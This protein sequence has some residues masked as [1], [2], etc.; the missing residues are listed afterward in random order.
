MRYLNC[1]PFYQSLHFLFV[2]LILFAWSKS[3]FL[4]LITVNWK[5]SV[6]KMF[7]IVTLQACE[8]LTLHLGHRSCCWTLCPFG[9]RC[10]A[11]FAKLALLHPLHGTMSLNLS[12]V[13]VNLCLQWLAWCFTIHSYIYIGLIGHLKELTDSHGAQMGQHKV[14]KNFIIFQHS[15]VFKYVLQQN[16]YVREI[17]HFTTAWVVLYLLSFLAQHT[18]T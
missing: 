1:A 8:V 5:C 17:L 13:C 11:Y 18:H 6:T 10:W 2:Y 7:K 9:L 3:F 12:I 14:F 15:H 4:W 16:Q